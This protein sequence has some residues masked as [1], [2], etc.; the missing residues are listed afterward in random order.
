MLAAPV[1]VLD[2]QK[3]FDCISHDILLSKLNYYGISGKAN[4]LLKSY[5]KNRYQ[6]VVIKDKFS[7]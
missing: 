6:R 1:H 4:K 3:A 5:I 2:L 7:N